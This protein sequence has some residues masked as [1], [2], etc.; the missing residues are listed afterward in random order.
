MVEKSKLEPIERTELFQ[1]A[2]FDDLEYLATKKFK[3]V[4]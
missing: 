3:L 2:N 4:T 1:E